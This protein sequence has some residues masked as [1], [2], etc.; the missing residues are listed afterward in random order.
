MLARSGPVLDDV[1][2]VI[3]GAAS[4]IG[5]ATAEAF[6]GAGA[7]TI[8]VDIDEGTLRALATS[9]GDR[10]RP[11]VVDLGVPDQVDEF[12]ADIERTEGRIDILVN[13][14]GISSK[15]PFLDVGEAEWDRVFA[16]NVEAALHLA[17]RVAPKMAERRAG[18][19]INVSSISGRGGGPSQSVY[20]ATKGVLLGLTRE[21]ATGL[22]PYSVRVN[23]VLPGV[24][25]TPM[26]RREH[27]GRRG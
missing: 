12:L 10:A 25:D 17:L 4:G 7:R 2:T 6:N 22:A 8:L 15:T 27:R 18:C 13:N 20:G 21:I 24:I 9:L 16:I 1:V 14:A 19:I 23:A 26:V 11:C 5:R 3:T